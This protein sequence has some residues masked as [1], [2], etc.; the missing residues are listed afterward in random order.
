MELRSGHSLRSSQQQRE[1]RISAL[2]D[3]LLILV[4][5]GL[6]CTAAAARTGVL[7]RRWRGLWT[8]LHQIVFC[9]VALASLEAALGSIDCPA[10]SL[11]E[12]RVPQRQIPEDRWPDPAVV[13]SLLRAAARLAPEKFVF[14]LQCI[15]TNAELPCFYR[16]TSIVLD[17]RILFL[18]VPTGVEFPVLETLSLSGCLVNLDTLLSRCPRLRMFRLKIKCLWSRKQDLTV[19]SASLQELV[20]QDQASWIQ[21]VHILAPSL[22]QLTISLMASNSEVTISV[23]APMLEK[24]SWYCRYTGWYVAF[25]LWRLEQLRL[26][27]AE[28]QGQ[29][30][31]LHIHACTRSRILHGEAVK[32][33][34]EIE[35]HMVVAFSVLELYLKTSGHVYGAL[36]FHLFGIDRIRNDMQ[37]LK[38]FLQK[39]MVEDRCPPDCPCVP[40]NWRSQTIF[41][42]A[43]E[44]VEIHRFEGGEHEIDFLKLIFECAPMLTRMNVKLSHK[45]SATSSNNGCTKIYNIFGAYPSVESCVLS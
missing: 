18:R 26:Q 20:V 36:V 27:T 10:V 41:L 40:T 19:H 8:G 23:L 1:D 4:L 30:P 45:A 17:S 11:V 12:I 21:H 43:L 14:H 29:L 15:S 32:F 28:R 2:P 13:D 42:T 9:D 16:A 33:T 6:R 5:A 38:I 31:S 7:S 44:E 3:D 24:V 34:R 35:K 37:R 25:G 22:K 39:S